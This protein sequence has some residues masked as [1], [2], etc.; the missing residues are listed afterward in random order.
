MMKVKPL[1]DRVVIE[2]A[3]PEKKTKSGIYLPESASER[4]VQGKVIAVG[5]GKTLDDGKH[6]ELS[7]RKGDNVIFSKFAGSEIEL[8]GKKH[9]IMK[10]SDILGVLE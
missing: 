5:P 8:K 9:L 10:E 7:V 6:A 1:E 4:P 3:E 2:P